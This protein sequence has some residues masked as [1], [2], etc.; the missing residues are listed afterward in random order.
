MNLFS[1]KRKKKEKKREHGQ[2]YFTYV[3]IPWDGALTLGLI[4]AM[5]PF[6][7]CRKCG[8]IVETSPSIAVLMLLAT[9]LASPLSGYIFARVSIHPE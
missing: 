2:L 4:L 8:S 5:N 3:H 6:R 1:S 9:R 7:R